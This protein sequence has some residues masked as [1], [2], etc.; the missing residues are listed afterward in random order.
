MI[1]CLGSDPTV[2]W[3]AINVDRSNN[4]PKAI[5]PQ[6]KR[7]SASFTA[8]IVAVGVLLIEGYQPDDRNSTKKKCDIVREALGGDLEFLNDRRLFFIDDST[9]FHFEN[10]V[11]QIKNP[12]VVCHH[13][14]GRSSHFA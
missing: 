3:S 7:R 4:S 8:R 1:F 12:V 10:S 6:E 2:F 13:D 14:G 11:G 9:I 5:D